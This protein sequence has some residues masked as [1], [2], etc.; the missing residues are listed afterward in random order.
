MATIQARQY[1]RKHSNYISLD[2]YDK[3]Y[4]IWPGSCFGC[5]HPRS[6]ALTLLTVRVES[7]VSDR[8]ELAQALLARAAAARSEAGPVA[9][10]LSEDLESPGVYTLQSVWHRRQDLEAYLGG[11]G[12]GILL[13]ALELLGR[14][15][16]FSLTRAEGD[17][18]DPM[19]LVRRIRG[20]MPSL[21]RAPT[22]SAIET[23]EAPGP[24]GLA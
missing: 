1:S 13:G 18:D 7:G 9:V 19:E 17:A 14:R 20:R 5:A 2:I 15:T 11:A 16:E 3:L 6:S 23:A 12:F 22:V 10:H 8:R 24:G 4:P 21:G